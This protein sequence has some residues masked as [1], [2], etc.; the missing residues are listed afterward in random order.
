MPLD[1]PSTAPLSR[2]RPE[3]SLSRPRPTGVGRGV[4]AFAA[5]WAGA[6][7]IAML[8]GAPAVVMVLAASGVA[9]VWAAITGPLALRRVTV[10]DVDLPPV[11][12]A[13]DPVHVAV[14]AYTATPAWAVVSVGGDRVASGWV[15]EGVTTLE[16]TAPRRGRFD[17]A[18]VAVSSA[19][20]LGLV[21]W[22]RRGRRTIATFEVGA[23][24]CEG[25]VATTRLPAD[26][27]TGSA[28][29]ARSGHDDLESVRPWR[30][31][32]EATAVHW[33]STL[34]VRELVVRQ[35]RDDRR[36]LWSIDART[37]RPDPDDEAGRVVAAATRLLANGATVWISEDGRDAC[38]VRSTTD[39][40]RWSARFDRTATPPAPPPWWR[41]PIE[42]TACEPVDTLR[43]WARWWVAVAALA[44][45]LMLLSPLGYG[46]FDLFLAA[47][48]VIAAALFTT[49][50][51]PLSRP[52]RQ[53]L[54][55]AIAMILLL[56]LVDLGSIVDTASALRNL[57][58]QL[59]VGL[60]VLQGFEIVD[61][62]AARV[63][64]ACSLLLT[65]YSAGIR[66]D[67]RL[68]P[69][70]LVAFTG[71]A[72][73]SQLVTAEDRRRPADADPVAAKGAARRR[74]PGI[75]GLAGA[76]AATVLLLAVVP[77]PAGPA[78]LT[79]PSWLQERRL[80]AGDGQ[81]ASSAGSPLLGGP[82]QG[83]GT[84]GGA[85]AGGY[86]GFSPTMDTAIRGP[87]SDEIVL[88]VRAPYADYW[89]GQTFTDFDGRVWKVDSEVG[90]RTPG[91]QHDIAP[92]TGD[93]YGQAPGDFVQTFFPAV[94][95]P[96]IVFAA[97]RVQQVLLDAPLW[98]R[99]DGGLRADVT[100]PA[101]SAYTVISRRSGVTDPLL[102]DEGD[103]SRFVVPDRY[104]AV[105]DSTTQRTR[106]LAQQ[107]QRDTTLDT[108]RAMEDW[109][110]ANVEY[111]L[112]APV[113]DRG[114]DAVDDFL[115]QSQR[116]FCEQIAT[117]LAIMLRTLG[118]PARIA[119]GYVPSDR[120]AVA[121]V[122]ISRASD[123]HAWVEVRFPDYGWVAF[124]PTASVPMSGEAGR[125]TVGGE[126]L[127]AFVELGSRHAL[128]LFLV[129]AAVGVVALVVRFVR[130][131][132]HRRARG[133]WGRLQDRFVA[134][135]VRRGAPPGADNVLLATAFDNPLAARVADEL[136]AS[137]F[138][139]EWT[140]DDE[141]YRELAS[142]MDL[143][144]RSVSTGT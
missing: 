103:I 109:L 125:H 92:A 106:D 5:A 68:G 112:N 6:A 139:A 11:A 73:A 126:L 93:L 136:D 94:D 59:L 62:R 52:V 76:V 38:E 20:R 131:A 137:A 96:N 32:D 17:Q 74:S 35:H 36:D 105:P 65:A 78:Q 61:R 113:P 12:T 142:V 83:D 140:D 50:P 120:D 45:I 82:L 41:R 46:T 66:I 51:I 26:D 7:M 88:R 9:F 141:R 8:T 138:A 132:L 111:D 24:P 85:G 89:R 122:W 118:V 47:L 37:G 121:G 53:L 108:I 84:R 29:G 3:G 44:P 128:Q 79:L 49:R 98:Q 19:G 72:V 18:T 116:G 90:D 67:S 48:A 56:L 133:R 117:S 2:P 54:G 39:L 119:T 107:L 95:L 129:V 13:G 99:P 31:G 69:W 58:P 123:A 81:L 101:G 71:I 102:R 10:D 42:L 4:P 77:V 114:E 40:Q 104:V 64:L 110:A 21:W 127:Q 143:L 57:M 100:L 70:L 16:G 15:H 135:A 33:P 75:A 22:Q 14:T 34:R 28:S 80:T 86:P 55:V 115:F 25:A 91:P 144:E 43:P 87:M 130:R 1:G 27:R 124:D 63:S 134:A 97:P 30:D 23:A 60:C